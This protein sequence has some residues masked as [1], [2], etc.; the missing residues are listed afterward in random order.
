MYQGHDNRVAPCMCVHDTPGSLHHDDLT[1]GHDEA[2]A[3]EK[4][5]KRQRRQLAEVPPNGRVP[6]QARIDPALRVKANRAAEALDISL[7]LYVAELIA[8][9]EVDEHGRPSWRPTLL[10]GEAPP[11]N[12]A[13]PLPGLGLSA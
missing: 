6:I 4:Y 12:K 13:D 5:G 11:H 8:R 9:D 1:E 3:R 2:V 10:S 7:S